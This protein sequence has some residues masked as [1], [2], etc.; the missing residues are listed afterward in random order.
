[1]ARAIKNPPANA[2][3]TRDTGSVLRLGSSPGIGSGNLSCHKN[4][5]DRG[6]WWAIAHAASKSEMR[7]SY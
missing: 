3:D 4:H 6:A 7:L 5:M 2:G 1:M